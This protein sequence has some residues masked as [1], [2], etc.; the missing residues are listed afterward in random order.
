MAS[1][2]PIRGDALVVANRADGGANR[3]MVLRVEGW[4]GSEPG[5]FVM[6]SPGAKS[7]AARTDPLLPRPMAV[8]RASASDGGADVE[9]LYK[10][11]GRGTRLLAD[12]RALLARV[13]AHHD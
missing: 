13:G 8:Y 9:I 4:P 2:A 12:A 11:S 7:A 1:A 10:V 6:L 3:R 5:Q